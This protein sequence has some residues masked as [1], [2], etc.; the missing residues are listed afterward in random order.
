MLQLE[1]T[2]MLRCELRRA[3]SAVEWSRSDINYVPSTLGLRAFYSG[4][5]IDIAIQ[6]MSIYGP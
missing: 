4:R 3:G 5:T 2:T 1:S 6:N